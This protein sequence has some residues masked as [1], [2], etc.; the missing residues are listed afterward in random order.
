VI[1]RLQNEVREKIDAT[2]ENVEIDFLEKVRLLFSYGATFHAQF[3][4]HFML[5]MQKNAPQVWK[6]CDEFR[7]QRMRQNIEKLVSEGVKSGVFRKD[8]NQQV[9][10]FMYIN[11]IQQLVTPT[12]L[13]QLPVT[14]KE[15]FE[16]I[17]TVFFEGILT[18]EARLKNVTTAI[19]Q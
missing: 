5:D 6:A 17:I 8:L 13:A 1:N 19:I 15:L 4:N 12:T 14:M 9:I 7:M 18:E 2:I 11:A 16:I 10:V 3:S